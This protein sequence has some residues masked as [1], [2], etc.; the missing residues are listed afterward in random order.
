M[1][2]HTEGTQSLM[3]DINSL[4]QLRVEGNQIRAKENKLR[5]ITV[6]EMISDAHALVEK[7]KHESRKRAIEMRKSLGTF[8][9]DVRKAAEIWKSRT[10]DLTGER[11]H[12]A[13]LNESMDKQEKKKGKRQ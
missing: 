6:S 8:G 4:Y 11:S 7:L 3:A 5:K 2:T 12:A 1:G 10:Y 9:G 13:G